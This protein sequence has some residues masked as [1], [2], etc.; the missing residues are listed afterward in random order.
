MEAVCSS[1]SSVEFYQ[2]SWRHIPKDGILHIHPC[3]NLRFKSDI[4][5]LE[6]WYSPLKLRSKQVNN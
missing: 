2:T 5:F 3:K 4:D 6:F 1:E